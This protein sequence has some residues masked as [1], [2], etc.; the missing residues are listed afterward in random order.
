MKNRK[1]YAALLTGTL[2]VTMMGT[3]VFASAPT[4]TGSTEIT[5]KGG[6]MGP[7]DPVTDEDGANNWVVSYPRN[8]ELTDSNI[9]NDA[10]QARAGKGVALNFT[11]TQREDIAGDGYAVTAGNVGNGLS[12]TATANGWSGATIPMDGRDSEIVNMQLTN[13]TT[14]NSTASFLSDNGQ[15]VKLGVNPAHEDDGY[16]TLT[17][18][19][20]P[21]AGKDYTKTVTW[22]VT[23]TG[24]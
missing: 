8:I 6:T 12:I 19:S 1:L 11:V 18:D 9:T 16:A 7:T 10:S 5:Y 17:S 15:I 24:A 20:K 14:S 3:T 23:R 4:G 21:I 22:T 2:A 13:G